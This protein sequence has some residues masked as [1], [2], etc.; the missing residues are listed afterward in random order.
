MGNCCEEQDLKEP[1][2]ENCSEE[3]DT[4]DELNEDYKDKP[5]EEYIL[6]KTLTYQKGPDPIIKKRREQTIHYGGFIPESKKVYKTAMA[7][8]L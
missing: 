4:K 7:D 1:K 5:N 8:D 6:N 3:Q 2:I